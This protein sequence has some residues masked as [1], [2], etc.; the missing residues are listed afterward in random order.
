MT[1]SS[2]PRKITVSTRPRQREEATADEM[3]PVPGIDPLRIL[4]DPRR[5]PASAPSTSRVT[6]TPSP[7]PPPGVDG[8]LVAVVD[9]VSVE[10]YMGS[11]G[12]TSTAAPTYL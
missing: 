2:C 9:Q 4:Q 10:K 12:R 8:D 6:K 11:P 1:C 7:A 3:R 5:L